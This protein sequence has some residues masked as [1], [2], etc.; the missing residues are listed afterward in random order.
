MTSASSF[1]DEDHPPLAPAEHSSLGT[2]PGENAGVAKK[3]RR[4]SNR[5]AVLVAVLGLGALMVLV[6]GCSGGHPA[7]LLLVGVVVGMLLLHYLT[8]GRLLSRN[9]ARAEESSSEK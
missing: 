2:P 9:S 6:I 5:I 4:H 1:D 8:W 3:N 7:V